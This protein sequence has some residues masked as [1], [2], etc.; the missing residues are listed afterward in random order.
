MVPAI[1]TNIWQSVAGPYLR[2][3]LTRLWPVFAC[4]VAAT[5]LGA[6]WLTEDNARVGT[7]V[8]GAILACYAAITL[9]SIPFAVPPRAQRWAGPAVGGLTGVTTAATGVSAIPV[10]PYLAAIGLQRD[11]LVQ[12]MGISFTLSNTALGI[13]LTS[14]GAL[15]WSTAPLVGVA[16]GSVLGGMWLG[17]RLRKRLDPATFRRWFLIGL[18]GLGVYLFLRSVF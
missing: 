4:A 2:E 18:L 5:L 16:L 14:V 12:A 6:G 3:L 10:V 13:S 15:S 1:A 11:M 7:A 9:S 17:G 8:L